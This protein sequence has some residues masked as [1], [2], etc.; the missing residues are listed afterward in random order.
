[1][2]KRF[3]GWIGLA[4]LGL[5]LG[6]AGPTHAMDGV[7]GGDIGSPNEFEWTWCTQANWTYGICNNLLPAGTHVLGLKLVNIN[8]S[9][10]MAL[11]D[12]ATVPAT[13]ATGLKDEVLSGT[14]NDGAVHVW[15]SPIRFTTGVSVSCTG[16]VGHTDKSACGVAHK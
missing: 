5:S 4:V 2:R 11:W 12:A 6:L 7:Q 10:G 8:A 1:M 3:G 14:A 15:P 13:G 9:S 16:I